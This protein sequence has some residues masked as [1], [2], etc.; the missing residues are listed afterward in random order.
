MTQEKQHQ[1]QVVKRRRL[2]KIAK[3]SRKVNRKQKPRVAF[4]TTKPP[5]KP[6]WWAYQHC[7]DPEPGGILMTHETIKDAKNR[8]NMAKVLDLPMNFDAWSYRKLR[9]NERGAASE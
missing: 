8:Y 7:Q 4:W 2:N 9:R 6:G 3:K 1:K 5:S